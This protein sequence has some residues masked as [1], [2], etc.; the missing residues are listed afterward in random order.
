MDEIN[1]TCSMHGRNEKYVGLAEGLVGELEDM[2]LGRL[3]CSLKGNI[4][5]N[6]QKESGRCGTDSS[7]RGWGPVAGSYEGSG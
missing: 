1:R 2:S 7:D 5:W 4:K 6:I 3:R